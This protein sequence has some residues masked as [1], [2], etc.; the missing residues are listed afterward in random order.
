MGLTES[1]HVGQQLV[2]LLSTHMPNVQTLHLWRPDD[3][4]WTSRKMI[5]LN[6]ISF[7]TTINKKKFQE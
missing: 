7:L 5:V 4:P 2:P 6:N 1:I 3:F